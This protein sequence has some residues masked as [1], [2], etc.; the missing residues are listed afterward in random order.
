MHL[1][2]KLIF[3]SIAVYVGVSSPAVA[4]VANVKICLEEHA[5]GR[6]TGAPL[7][8]STVP[9]AEELLRVVGSYFGMERDISILPCGIVEK[10]ESWAASSEDITQ[11]LKA[12]GVPAGRYVIYN[13]VWVREVIGNDRDQA[14]FVFGHEFGHFVRGH[15]FERKQ[16]AR[17]LKELEADRFGGCATARMKSNW[18]SVESLVSRIRPAAGD[19]YY[20][21]ATDSLATVK[22]GF[23]ACGGLVVQMCRSPENGVERW[24]YE[25]TFDNESNWRGGGGSRPGYCAEAAAELK[26]KYPDRSELEV[27]TSNETIRDTCSPFRCIQYKY[28][29]TIKV[30]GDPT[31]LEAACKK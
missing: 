27:V 10:V 1:L 25:V 31:Y 4:D 3:A 23:A 7:V 12:A 8:S 2:I 19:G 18:S 28:F 30:K 16:I 21:S 9:N 11:E 26:K 5:S 14:I 13:P 6:M 20:P 24:G 17:D 29:C 15:F 22:E